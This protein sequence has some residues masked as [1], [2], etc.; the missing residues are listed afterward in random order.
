MVQSTKSLLLVSGPATCRANRT[1]ERALIV[2]FGSVSS[3][4]PYTEKSVVQ[5]REGKMLTV[6]GPSRYAIS[7][8]QD[9]WTH[10][11]RGSSVNYPGRSRI[12]RRIRT[13]LGVDFWPES[14]LIVSLILCH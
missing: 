5:C 6:P 11:P 13:L 8:K 7:G 14:A 10:V 12:A 2:V 9:H 4:G 3:Q 1:L